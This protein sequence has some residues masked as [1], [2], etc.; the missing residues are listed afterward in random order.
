M[1]A[2]RG[3][4]SPRPRGEE[5]AGAANANLPVVGP[6]DSPDVGPVVGEEFGAD[7]TGRDD[8]EVVGVLVPGVLDCDDALERLGAVGDGAP[9]GAGFGARGGAPDARRKTGGRV[10]VAVGRLDGCGDDVGRAVE[11]ALAGGGERVLGGVDRAVDETF[12]GGRERVGVHTPLVRERRQVP[13]GAFHN[14]FV[15][16][17]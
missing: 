10:D 5:V 13:S 2:G 3:K 15:T 12:V 1:G 14:T 9:D 17:D 4:V 6:D 8:A 11:A 7:A 16:H